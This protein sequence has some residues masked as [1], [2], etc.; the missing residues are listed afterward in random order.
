[1]SLIYSW[2]LLIAL[3]APG[4]EIGGAGRRPSPRPFAGRW[5]GGWLSGLPSWWP[6][7][8]P[9]GQ[10][11]AGHCWPRLLFHRRAAA[12]AHINPRDA[13]GGVI[14]RRSG[15]AGRPRSSSRWPSWSTSTTDGMAIGPFS[16][17]AR[18]WV[19]SRPTG[20]ARRIAQVRVVVAV[21]AAFFHQHGVAASPGILS[22]WPP[23]CAAGRARPAQLFLLAG[24]SAG[25]AMYL[26]VRPDV[27]RNEYYHPCPGSPSPFDAVRVGVRP[28][29]RTG[30][31]PTRPAS[32]VVLGVGAAVL[33]VA[34]V[35]HPD[36]VRRRS[37]APTRPRALGSA[38]FPLLLMVGRVRAG[39]RGVPR[40]CGSHCAG[41]GRR[42]A[43]GRRRRAHSHPG[44]R[45]PRVDHGHVQRGFRHPNRRRRYIKK[46]IYLSR[47]KVESGPLGTAITAARTTSWRPNDH[48]PCRGAPRRPACG[49]AGCSG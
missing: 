27:G 12:A 41:W 13:D 47:S 40:C 42:C 46:N 20:L 31:G 29:L 37:V 19:S 45:R 35:V 1:M 7:R 34:L 10:F 11:A 17:L 26:D 2:L 3:I 4:A 38:S 39:H 14:G 16:G 33:A 21:M 48:M 49:P 18:Y 8:A 25:P 9:Q 23:C 36:P 28:G 30:P 43:G 5:R 44:V 24:A 22:R 32:R 6:R 15:L